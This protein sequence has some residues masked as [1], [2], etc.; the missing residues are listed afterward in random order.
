M[1]AAVF[2]E[3]VC[4]VM[5]HTAV[6][7]HTFFQSKFERKC[8]FHNLQYKLYI[9]NISYFGRKCDFLLTNSLRS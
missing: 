2:L 7:G 3:V 8:D 9:V 4:E 1:M 5:V 6:K